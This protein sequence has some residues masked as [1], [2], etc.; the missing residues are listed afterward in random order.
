MMP[1][2]NWR[3]IALTLWLVCALLATGCAVTGTPDP[4]YMDRLETPFTQGVPV[5]QPLPP[6]RTESL[7][8]DEIDTAKVYRER[9]RAVVNVTSLGANRTRLHET[10]PTSGVGSGFILAGMD[11][12]GIVITNW[13]VIDE[14]QR[15]IVSLYDGSRYPA[16]LVGSDPELD[17]AVLRFDPQGR[18]LASI[19]A[20]NS[21]LLQVGQKVI[22]L[23]NP[24]GLDGTLTTGVVSAVNRPIE[25]PSGL[26]MRNFIQT[27]A[28]INPGNSGG[29]LLDREGRVIGIASM[30]ITPTAASAGI[31]L[32]IPINAAER[33][34][35][36]LLRTG[37][38]ARGWIDIEGVALDPQLAA[39]AAMDMHRGILVTRVLP[40]GNAERAGLRGGRDGRI[41]RHGAY[42][43]PVGGDVIIAID[44]EEVAGLP[45]LLAALVVSR[46]G[47]QVTVTFMRG[48]ERREVSVTLGPRTDVDA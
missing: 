23:G 21:D 26:I 40:N 11:E 22:A 45:D 15:L 18:E 20:G 14:A 25:M 17:L 27:D 7:S 16:R 5:E 37:R 6:L 29:P 36:E 43:I 33:V 8:P 44:G 41:V 1:G 4:G 13:H 32:A 19:P 38:V 10:V 34:A 3:C 12:P 9:V 35:E 30:I 39:A 42:R 47:D 48:G 24:F 31:G 28:A 46:P 2:S